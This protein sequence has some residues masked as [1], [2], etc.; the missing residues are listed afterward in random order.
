MPSAASRR[1]APAL[2]AAVA[3]ALGAGLACAPAQAARADRDEPMSI[4]SNSE[5]GSVVDLNKKLAVF[6]GNVV[7]KQGTLVIKADR[8]ELKEDPDGRKIGI[9][10]GTPDHPANF[11]QRSDRPD[12]WTEGEAQRI[13][14]DSEA[15][16]VRFV[17]AAHLRVLRNDQ[18]TDEG[19]AAVISYDTQLE[20]IQFDG[21][22]A[23]GTAAA[24]GASDGSG[25]THVVF[26]PRQLR[27][28]AAASA[29]AAAPASA[30]GD[31]R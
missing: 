17:G 2:V 6:I 11:R 4:D 14:Y 30:P 22:P 29:P 13:E 7:I 10:I 27:G 1:V 25:R 19:R 18:V 20:T 28:N 31:A 9:A 15:N 24:S 8:L 26:Q 21:K 23:T 16:R 5:K 3:L 12:E